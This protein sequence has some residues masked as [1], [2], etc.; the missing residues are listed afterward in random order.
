MFQDVDSLLSNP[1]STSG[2]FNESGYESSEN[3]NVPSTPRS[4]GKKIPQYVATFTATFSAVAGGLVLAWTSPILDDLKDGKYRHIPLDQSEIGWIGSFVTLG[5]MAMCIPTGFVCD[6]IGRKKTL[7]LLVIPF[8]VGWLLILLAENIL[9]IYFGR[10]ITGMAVGAC[11]IAT[12]LYVS[13]IAHKTLRGTLGSYFQLM[14]TVGIL[15]AYLAGKF[16]SSF[17]FTILCSVFP[18]AFFILFFFQP[19]SPVYL[20]KK[21]LYDQGKLS[22]IRL[23]GDLYN[24]D[25][26]INEIEGCLKENSQTAISLT[27][28]LKKKPAVKAFIIS[29]SLSFFQQFCGINAVIF[30]ASD[31][32]ATSGTNI[33]SHTACIIVGIFQVFATFTSSLVI[34]KLGRRVL[35]LISTLVIW[36]SLLQ[37][38]VYF[39]L[40]NR[41]TID[42]HTVTELG[43][44][45]VG[46]LCLFIIAYSLGLGPVPWVISSE[47]FPIEIKSIVSSVSISFNWFLA[48]VLT[49][50]YLPVSDSVGKDST[51]YF[52]STMSLI[53]GILVYFCLPETKG[54]TVNEI[55]KE[56]DR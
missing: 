53:G 17:H 37:L 43:F 20:M 46:S 33:D 23:R 40:K 30:Y 50:Y 12:P 16:L 9:M 39:T 34:D 28:M 52:F 19:E 54:K 4:S 27:A 42:H 32:F 38:A 45:P 22:L 10:I 31:I 51:Y 15:V 7:L 44:L 21:G 8:T 6:L 49:K 29:A 2:I 47:I 26:E 24:V 18:G 5:A 3:R 41:T 56:L 35:L 14:I 55:Q 11:C 36:V 25:A 1:A 13:E 48:F